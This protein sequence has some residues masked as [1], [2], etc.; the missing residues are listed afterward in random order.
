MLGKVRYIRES[1]CKGCS[2]EK[3]VSQLTKKQHTAALFRR[4][5][6]QKQY[7]ENGVQFKVIGVYDFM[8]KKC[9]GI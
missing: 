2:N 6:F 1:R 4:D 7:E 8:C 3:I 9:S 5:I